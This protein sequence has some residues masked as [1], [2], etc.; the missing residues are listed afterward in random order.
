MAVSSPAGPPPSRSRSAADLVAKP[1]SVELTGINGVRIR[2]RF[3]NRITSCSLLPI[4]E[5]QWSQFPLFL[6]DSFSSSNAPLASQL[7]LTGGPVL[8]GGS[9]RLPSSPT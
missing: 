4:C 2:S 6:A 1:V 3:V 9:E 8:T 7:S 5:G